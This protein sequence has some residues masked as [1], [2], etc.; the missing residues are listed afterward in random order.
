MCEK[1]LVVNTLTFCWKVMFRS[2]VYRKLFVYREK[3]KHIRLYDGLHVCAVLYMY[4]FSF[5]LLLLRFLSVNSESIC[6]L[7][8]RVRCTCL[9]VRK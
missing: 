5:L 8:Q 6:T 4:Y 9:C 7:E 3:G 2:G 1:C